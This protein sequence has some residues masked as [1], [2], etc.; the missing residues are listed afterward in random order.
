M[1]YI[2]IPLFI[3]I[4][5]WLTLSFIADII[6]YREKLKIHPSK[7]YNP[8]NKSFVWMIITAIIFIY[9]NILLW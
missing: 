6:K 2:T 7:K 3:I 1:R 8:S 4:Y 5:A 9:F